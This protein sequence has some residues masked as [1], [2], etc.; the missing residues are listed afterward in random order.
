MHD[1][2][3]VRCGESL[4]NRAGNFNDPVRR[5]T[6]RRDQPIQRLALEQFHGD[7]VDVIGFL[8]R[9]DRDHVGMIE[10]GN[11]ASL[12]L[13]AGQPVGIVGHRGRQNFKSYLPRQLGIRRAVHLS[14]SARA[15][16]GA[17]AVVGQRATSQTGSC[18]VVHLPGLHA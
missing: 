9:V 17:D 14:H 5:Q 16:C 13:E 12:A 15:N 11:G 4:G 6:I 7:E 1:A 2:F 3:L 18:L 8:D 10:R